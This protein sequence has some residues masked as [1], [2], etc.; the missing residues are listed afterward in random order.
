MIKLLYSNFG[1]QI[2]LDRYTRIRICIRPLHPYTDLYPTT[3]PVYGSVSDRYTCIRIC[4][5]PL[6]PYTDLYPTA[7]PYTDLYP[8]ATPVYGSV[9]DRYTCIRAMIQTEAAPGLLS[10]YGLLF[11]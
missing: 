11:G 5:R 9:S 6:H 3:T 10:E 7:T 1:Q 4:I 2:L 8:T